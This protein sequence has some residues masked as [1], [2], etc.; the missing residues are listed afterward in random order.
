M[1]VSYPPSLLTSQLDAG[2]V[3]RDRLVGAE[4]QQAVVERLQLHGDLAE[5]GPRRELHPGPA[6]AGEHPDQ[7]RVAGDDGRAVRGGLPGRQVQPVGDG[8]PGPAGLH[9]HRAGAV[10]LA[11]RDAA[12]LR[13][14]A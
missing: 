10:A 6:G 14:D 8:Q 5:L 11:Q 4:H 12:A 2:G 1:A 7:G 3:E 13:G 9:G